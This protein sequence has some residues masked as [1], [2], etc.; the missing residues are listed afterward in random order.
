MLLGNSA[1]WRSGAVIRCGVMQ[2][3]IAAALRAACIAPALVLGEAERDQ[4]IAVLAKAS[5][6]A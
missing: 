4:V 5:G 6:M 3:A 2:G 1:V